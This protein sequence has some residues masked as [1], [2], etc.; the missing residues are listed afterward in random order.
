MVEEEEAIEFPDEDFAIVDL[1]DVLE[2]INDVKSEAVRAVLFTS[3]AA[4]STVLAFALDTCSKRAE[5][6]FTMETFEKMVLVD[7][8]SVKRPEEVKWNK[9]QTLL[10]K[11]FGEDGPVDEDYQEAMK[12]I[13]IEGQAAYFAM[14]R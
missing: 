4:S 6:P 13:P 8:V 12:Y 11:D 7:G 2:K 9:L 5:M 10:E 14:I 3:A 1:D